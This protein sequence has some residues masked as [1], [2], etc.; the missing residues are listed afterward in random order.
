MNIRRGLIVDLLYKNEKYWL[1]LTFYDLHSSHALVV[2]SADGAMSAK[3]TS[4]WQ[5]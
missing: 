1:S 4:A 2:R 3:R 5:S